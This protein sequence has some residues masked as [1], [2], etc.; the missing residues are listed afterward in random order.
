[1]LYFRSEAVHGGDVLVTCSELPDPQLVVSRVAEDKKSLEIIARAKEDY[2]E[3][4]L[5]GYTCLAQNPLQPEHF[6]SSSQIIEDAQEGIRLWEINPE[7]W[8]TDSSIARATA[9]MK[10]ARTS[11]AQIEPT[12]FLKCPGG[13]QSMSWASS[14]VLVAGCA[15][16]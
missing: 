9:P 16:H 13:V 4:V 3:E 12:S 5:C 11:V 14:T 2:N 8:A 6:A 7:K 15:D 1:M 10:R